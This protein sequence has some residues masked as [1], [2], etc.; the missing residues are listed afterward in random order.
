LHP[1]SAVGRSTAVTTPG[2]VAGGGVERVQALELVRGECDA[3]SGGVLFDAGDP[4]GAG[5]GSDVVAAGEDPGEG[6]LGRGG[7]D[8][9]ADG[10]DFVDD[11][12]V[13][14][15]VLAGEP[16]VGLTPVV[17]GEVVDGADL[18][19]QQAVSER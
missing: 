11:G 4:A 5:D 9:G 10:G 6:G 14:L 3:V 17:V 2:A 19:G 18:S 13:A 7:A 15:E 16:R 12:E 1:E 8:L